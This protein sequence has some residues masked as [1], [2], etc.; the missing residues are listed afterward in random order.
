MNNWIY[1][2]MLKLTDRVVRENEAFFLSLIQEKSQAKL[3][4]IGCNNAEF[5]LKISQVLKASVCFGIEL[6]RENARVAQARGVKVVI[7]DA[8]KP[9]AFRD[10]SFDIITANQIIEHLYDTD[11]FFREI[12]RV[13]KKGGEAII[14]SPNLCSWHNVFFMLLG[15][16]P[17][18]MQLVGVQ[19]GNFL[20]GLETHGHIKL[21]SPRAIKN[22]SRLYGFT[23]EKT[24]AN[25]YYPFWGILARFFA[26][27][28]KNHAVF[29]ILKIRKI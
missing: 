18:G 6:E 21:F 19:A 22:I 5:T 3:L 9:F 26:L 12:H 27:L 29:F 17:P 8:N 16:Q 7:S 25:G 11:N 14:S 15:M 2:M 13:L 28:D 24:H 23:I 20:E 4:D 10:D 1:K